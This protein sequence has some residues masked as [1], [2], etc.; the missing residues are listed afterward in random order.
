MVIN[1]QA[2]TQ[3]SH[4][5][6]KTAVQEIYRCLAVGGTFWSNMFS[7]CSLHN[8]RDLGDGIWGDIKAGLLQGVK[9]H[10]IQN[11]RSLTCMV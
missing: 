5:R 10:S 4:S 8:G 9:L 2:L 1:R 11:P 7:D 3:V 6:A